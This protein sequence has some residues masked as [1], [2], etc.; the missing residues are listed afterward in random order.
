M[1]GNRWGVA[2]GNFDGVHLGHRALLKKL[3]NRKNAFGTR[4]MAFT[5]RQH[6]QNVLLTG[7]KIPL[8]YPPEKKKGIIQRIGIDKVEMIDF[9]IEFSNMEPEDFFEKYILSRYSIEY[10]VVGFNYR[11][12]K[13][14]R[15]DPALIKRLGEKKG[16][17][18]EIVEPVIL[19]GNIISSSLIRKLL[20]TGNI[21]DANRCL[22]ENFSVKGRVMKGNGRGRTMG[23]PTANISLP[24]GI[25]YP[26]RGVYVTITCIEGKRHPSITNVGINPTFSGNKLL[27]ETYIE[28]IDETLYDKEIEVEFVSRIRNERKFE[29]RE[30]LIRQLEIDLTYMNKYFNSH[31]I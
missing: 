23:F 31:K 27:I 17:D 30:E 4:T 10:V 7:N 18:V 25:L 9:T 5:F 24:E 16:F 28:G 12:G 3:L 20:S 6:P 21:N 29:D 22:G 11:F 13:G 19:N 1:D 14:G 15:G 2:L 26:C 8:I